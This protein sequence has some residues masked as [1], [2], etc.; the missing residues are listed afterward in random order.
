MDS[1]VTYHQQEST[2]FNP[3][4]CTLPD[5]KTTTLYRNKHLLYIL[6]LLALVI[7]ILILF[8][9]GVV[10][11]AF[12]KS[13]KLRSTKYILVFSLCLTDMITG[14]MVAIQLFS[15]P[16]VA[17]AIIVA[18]LEISI[19]TNLAIAVDRLNILVVRA[20]KPTG[21]ATKKQLI[22]FCVV[23]WVCT[24]GFILPWTIYPYYYILLIYTFGPWSVVVTMTAVSAVYVAIFYTIRKI[25]K[26]KKKRLGKCDFKRTKLVV[27]AYYKIVIALGICWLPW[28]FEAIRISFEMYLIPDSEH[29]YEASTA[30]LFLLNLGLLNSAVNVIIYWRRFPEF[31]EAINNLPIFKCLKC[32]SCQNKPPEM[33]THNQQ[34]RPSCTS[35]YDGHALHM[36][37]H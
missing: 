26:Q 27:R 15:P 17:D 19:L 23:L 5:L 6:Y 22:I 9:N 29:C 11:W 7:T 30:L 32:K 1:N 4:N 12:T 25:D 21:G 24:L 28:S 8:G 2:R 33:D 34:H 18:L 14:V 3:R 36:E 31:R 35:V 16:S 37:L 13:R 20:K 10:L